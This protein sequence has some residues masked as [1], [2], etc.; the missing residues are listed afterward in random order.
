[1]LTFEVFIFVLCVYKVPLQDVSNILEQRVKQRTNSKSY[2]AVC[3]VDCREIQ[4]P[5][6]FGLFDLGTNRDINLAI[7]TLPTTKIKYED[8]SC[9][10]AIFIINY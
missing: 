2:E 8:S 7:A 4:S 3:E 5:P 10:Q 1:M 6:C 9:V